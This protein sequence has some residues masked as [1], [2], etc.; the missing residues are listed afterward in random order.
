LIPSAEYAV[1]HDDLFQSPTTNAI[2]GTSAI[3]DTGATIT[4]AA[5]DAI[6]Y[7]GALAFA[8]DGVSEG[9]A[10]YW[11]KGIQL[12]LGKKFFMEVRCYTVDADDTDLI[13]GLSDLTAVTNPE[14]IYTT[15]AA[16]LIA[17][18]VLDG[19]ATVSLLCDKDNSGSTADLGSYDLSDATWHTLAIEVT[20]T[21]AGSTMVCKGYVDG[22][23]AVTFDTESA[24]PDDLALAPFIAF[25]TGGDA[26]HV[27]YFDYVR[28]SIER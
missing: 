16:N 4:A 24:I 26:A 19:D 21:A 25:R 10:L 8:S 11:P 27:G 13:F 2:P 3:I 7:H 9:A 23:L 15:T 12:G 18:G 5:T 20:G 14:D 17:F 28:W 1:F 6:S 22:Q